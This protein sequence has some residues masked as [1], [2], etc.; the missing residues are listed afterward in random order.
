MEILV[1]EEYGASKWFSSL[2]IL[3]GTKSSGANEQTHRE[4][5]RTARR[6]IDSFFVVACICVSLQQAGGTAFHLDYV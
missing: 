6:H 2:K 5:K 3:R 4:K 1:A